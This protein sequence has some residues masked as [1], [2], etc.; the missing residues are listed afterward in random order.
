[1]LEDKKGEHFQ[2]DRKYKYTRKQIK[3]EVLKLAGISDLQIHLLS[4]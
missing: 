3:P 4:I 2:E 1:V